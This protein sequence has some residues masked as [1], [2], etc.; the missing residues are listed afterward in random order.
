MTAKP[1]KKGA[2]Y[3]DLCDVP[4]HFIAEIFDGELYATPRP[5]LPHA[6]A[7]LRG[8]DGCARRAVRLDRARFG[9]ALDLIFVSR[10][11]VWRC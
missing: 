11:V 2:T 7:D 8:R 5:A 9:R 3:D 1:L 10:P 4:D 6:H